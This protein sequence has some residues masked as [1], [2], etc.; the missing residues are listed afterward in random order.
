MNETELS[1]HL[2]LKEE[3]AALKQE[4]DRYKAQVAELR[5]IADLTVKT[6]G[7]YMCGTLT[8]EQAKE[9]RNKAI[10]ALTPPSEVK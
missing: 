2:A 5:S 3:N 7:L 6:L 8:M 1:F 9:T 4:R 10:Q